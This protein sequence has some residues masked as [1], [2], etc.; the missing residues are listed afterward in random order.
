MVCKI[1][2]KYLKPEVVC[3]EYLNFIQC[4]EV[5]FKTDELPK[6]LHSD[7]AIT[8]DSDSELETENYD[9][10]DDDSYSLKNEIKNHESMLPVFR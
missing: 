4:F 9:D 10:D 6:Y 3:N 1:Y 8:K 5:F 2:K 7:N